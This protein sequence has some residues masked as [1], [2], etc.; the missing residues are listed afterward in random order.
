MVNPL[1]KLPFEL[2]TNRNFFTGQE[3]KEFEGQ[4]GALGLDPKTLYAIG[5]AIPFLRRGGEGFQATQEEGLLTGVAKALGLDFAKDYDVEK[6]TS[7]LLGRER[8]QLEDAMKA[9]QQDGEKI[10][11]LPELRDLGLASD[12]QV[13]EKQIKEFQDLRK[14]AEKAGV[15]PA[16]VGLLKQRAM[17]STT[18][19]L[20]KLISAMESMGLP[21]DLIKDIIKEHLDTDKQL[22][23]IMR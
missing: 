2:A 16:V 19:E 13:N 21:D 23:R 15:D 14:R 12:G 18:D 4:K 1:V 20:P 3:I 22:K 7:Q 11:N 17:K 6:F 10:L 5:Q 8:G 9:L